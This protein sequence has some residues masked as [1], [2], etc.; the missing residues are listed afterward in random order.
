VQDNKAGGRGLAYQYAFGDEAGQT[1]FRFDLGVTRYF[2]VNLVLVNDPQPL[3]EYVDRVRSRLG[4]SPTEE[5]SF[6]KSSNHH[7]HDFL[8]GLSDL[9]FAARAIV[10]DKTL[11][12]DD[13]RHMHS[14]EFYAFFVAQLLNH[15]PDSELDRTI[16][17]LDHFGAPKTALRCIRQELVHL[18][19]QD[20]HLLKRIAFKQS[21]GENG[22]QVADMVAGAIFRWQ[23]KHDARFV[24]HIWDK[25]LLWKYRTTNPPT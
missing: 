25:T 7:R 15:L 9:D 14:V 23:E 13:F 21:H 16:L 6:N 1:G 2:I 10:V 20:R 12:P 3:R 8:S 4:L 5:F 11:L 24:T 19:P 22:I 17:H 18:R